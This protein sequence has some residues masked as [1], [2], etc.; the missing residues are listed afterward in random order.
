MTERGANEMS[1]QSKPYAGLM[2]NE[3]I[4]ADASLPGKSEENK[5]R[6]WWRI[7]KIGSRL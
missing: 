7:E 1:D 5:W 6:G 3:E 2:K 4:D